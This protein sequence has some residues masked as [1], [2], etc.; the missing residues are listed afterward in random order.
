MDV[1]IQVS[2]AKKTGR[3]GEYVSGTP[4]ICGI[5]GTFAYSMDLRDA[6]VF[7]SPY[8]ALRT[9][10][11]RNEVYLPEDEAEFALVPVEL[12]PPAAPTIRRLI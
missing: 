4:G 2:D 12:I 9:I 6:W 10:E 5:S 8:A 1:V 7:T 11:N 3:V